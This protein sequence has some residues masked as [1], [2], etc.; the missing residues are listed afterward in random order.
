MQHVSLA[1]PSHLVPI[2][3]TVLFIGGLILLLLWGDGIKRWGDGILNGLSRP[4][5]ATGRAVL[6]VGLFAGLGNAALTWIQGPP[7]PEV[8]DEWSYLLAGDTFASGR[9]TNPA[10]PHPALV[11]ENVIGSPSYQS[12]YPPATGLILALG[13]RLGGHPVV[14]LWLSAGLLAA[15]CTWCFQAWLP[16]GWAMFGGLL[17]AFR[18]GLGSY[19]NQSYWGGTI[20]AIGGALL[21]GA[22]LRLTKS[23]RLAN[24][25]LLA[26]GLALLANSRPLEGLLVSLPAG[27]MLGRWFVG[28]KAPARRAATLKVVLPIA[29]ML[30]LTAAGVAYYNWRVTGEASLMPHF[31]YKELYQTHSEFVWNRRADA[32]SPHQIPINPGGEEGTS[33]LSVGL[34]QGSYR[35]WLVFFFMLSPA[36]AVPLVLGIGT[37]RDRSAWTLVVA[38]LLV[39]FSHFAVDQ[40]FPHYAAPLTAPLWILALMILRSLYERKWRQRS[41]GAGLGIVASLVIVT[42]F[43]VQVPALRS[44]MGSPSRYREQVRALLEAEPGRHL[45]LI[46]PSP[47]FNLNRADLRGTGVLW[48]FDDGAESNR[49]LLELFPERQRWQIVLEGSSEELQ[50]W[51][52]D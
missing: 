49:E 22:G 16:P 39:L 31:H 50:P 19:W 26:L 27:W 1:Y 13:Q 2:L 17:L 48:A 5:A 42:S 36:L 4:A 35:V 30:V 38:C 18:L 43:L 41:V 51:A 12:K 21:Y 47:R 46:H 44:D 25:L 3:E 15:A 29:L 33:W 11:G 8:S 6:L 32:S 9:L 52:G 14:G 20:A 37:L 34:L 40:F 10:S 28:L 45:V 24:S 23:P 7:I